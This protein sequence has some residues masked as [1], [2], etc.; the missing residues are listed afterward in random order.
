[1][2]GADLV[3][4]CVEKIVRD[5]IHAAAAHT[6]GDLDQTLSEIRRWADDRPGRRCL[7]IQSVRRRV[8]S[9]P[10]IDEVVD[11]VFELVGGDEGAA[12]SILEECLRSPL[13][14]DRLDRQIAEVAA[15]ALR[16][17]VIEACETWRARQG[18]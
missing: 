7:L 15:A 3:F 11:G 9:L 8:N 14:R 6:G 17:W 13:L 12:D 1:M 10:V 16:R 18:L 5:Q 4:A 2:T